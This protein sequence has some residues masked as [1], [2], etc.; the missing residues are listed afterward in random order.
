MNRVIKQSPPAK[1][2][3][4]GRHTYDRVPGALKGSFVTLLSPPQCHA[5][6]GTMPHTLASV[7]KSP[8]RRPSTLTPSAARTPGVGFW[9]GSTFSCRSKWP[10]GLRRRSAAAWLL[11]SRVRILLKAWMFVSCL[12]VCCYSSRGV[13]PCV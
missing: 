4:G 11:G 13:L 5:A 6:F 2:H 1:A 12:F 8:I 9:K 7:D 10:R 3:A